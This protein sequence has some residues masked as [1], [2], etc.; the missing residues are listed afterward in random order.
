M[1]DTPLVSI[2]IPVY[3]AEA[4]LPRC[5]TSLDK[6]TY[7]HLE[8]IFVDDASIDGSVGLLEQFK[9]DA[10]S[11][12]RMVKILRHGVNKGV[13]A[14]RNLAL[15][16][17]T[18]E[19]VYSLDSDDYIDSEA[20]EQMVAVAEERNADIVGIDW[21]LTYEKN[22]RRVNQANAKTGLELFQRFCA[23]V[24]RWNLWLWMIRRQLIE[25]YGFR[26]MPGINMG[27]DLM[28]MLK[29]SIHA[30]NV[31]ML[32]KPYYHYVQTNANALTKK[33]SQQYM[34]QIE[35][36]VKEAESYILSLNSGEDRLSDLMRL[37]LNI[38]LPLLISSKKSDYE[39]W[40]KWFPES[41]SY[42]STN[43]EL[44]FRTKMI[45]L[46]ALKKQYWV[47]WLYHNLVIK[48]VYGVLYR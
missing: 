9:V 47:L 26:F 46:A 41:N 15:D 33:W 20:I 3:N 25:E 40:Q 37:K 1:S 27:E 12:G 48:F 30:G 22:E 24:M 10:E 42:I 23:G 8:I 44:P 18:G 5:L 31:A 19:Y 29:L 32:K 11:K 28:L 6:Q 34:G 13:A 17:A 39:K 45:Q 35:A 2:I 14:A 7:R 16:N 43:K 38:K 4:G 36:N 21:N